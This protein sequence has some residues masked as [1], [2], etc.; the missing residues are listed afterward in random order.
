MNDENLRQINAATYILGIQR[1]MDVL[2]EVSSRIEHYAVEARKN[3]AAWREIGDAL[4]ITAQAAFQRYS[5][6][7]QGE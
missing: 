1:E 3:G 2:T 7:V 4:G 5:Q 6:L